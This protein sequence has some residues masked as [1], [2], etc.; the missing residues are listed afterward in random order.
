MLIPGGVG[1]TPV[2][3]AQA[4]I[5]LQKQDGVSSGDGFDFYGLRELI[6]HIKIFVKKYK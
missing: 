3:F 4:F 1:R 2:V 5:R 6:F